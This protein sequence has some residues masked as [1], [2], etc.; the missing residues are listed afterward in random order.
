MKKKIFSILIAVIMLVP[1]LMLAGCGKIK[2]LSGK[3]LVYAKVVVSKSLNKDDY[4]DK[5][6]NT[7][8]TFTEDGEVVIDD[9]ADE[10]TSQYKFENG[11]LYIKPETDENYP[12][13]PFA[14]VDGKYLV[15]SQ[16]VAG[17]VVKVY[18]K[19]R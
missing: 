3:T 4:K 11:R 17:G 5:Y 7:T 13:E 18:F 15:H 9:G 6:K 8:L 2:E 19:V 12:E 1:C 14:E 16:T 10:S